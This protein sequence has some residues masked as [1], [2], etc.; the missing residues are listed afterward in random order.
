MRSGSRQ[1]RRD[2]RWAGALRF[3]GRTP[4][5][6]LT[7]HGRR[8][9]ADLAQRYGLSQEALEAMAHAVARG[10]GTMAQF[11]IPDLG[12]SGQWMAGGMTMVG[13]MFDHSR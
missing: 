1:S 11:N 3:H 8:T 2:M 7:E 10:G 12:G 13:D 4:K 9:L 6:Q 5:S